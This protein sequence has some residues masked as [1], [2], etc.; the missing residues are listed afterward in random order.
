[1]PVLANLINTD[2]SRGFTVAQVAEKHG[3]TDPMVWS[4]ALEDKNDRESISGLSKKEY[5]EFL[6]AF[7]ALLKLNAK[8]RLAFINA[9]WRFSA[10]VVAAMQK[11]RIL[12]VTSRI[13]FFESISHLLSA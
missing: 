12:G 11:K 10:V 3:W 9:D 6:E 7:F 2:L 8:I 13:T 4:L 5:L 1:M